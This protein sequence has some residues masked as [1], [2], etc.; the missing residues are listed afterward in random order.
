M[1][2]STAAS[3]AS[4]TW[5]TTRPVF[6]MPSMSAWFSTVMTVRPYSALGRLLRSLG[7]GSG[8]LGCLGRLGSLRAF[9][10]LGGFCRF[11]C[12]A[13]VGTVGVEA[14]FEFLLVKEGLH[15]ALAERP[16]ATV[17]GGVALGVDVVVGGFEVHVAH[18]LEDFLGAA[19]DHR[20]LLGQHLGDFHYALFQFFARHG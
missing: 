14:R 8:S 19:Q 16:A 10:S 12:L 9:G 17:Q 6:R 2:G 11:G 13:F 20:V 7:L 1:P 3:M 4:R 5:A 15:G 18:A